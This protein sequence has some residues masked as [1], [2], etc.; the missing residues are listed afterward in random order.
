MQVPAGDR[1]DGALQFGEREFGRHQLEHHRAVF[2]LGAQ[3]RDRGGE[4]AAVV[5]AHRL[6]ERGQLA[7]VQR[8]L[9]AVAPRF[10]DQPRLV[11]QLV[12][13]EHLLLVPGRAADAE[14]EPQPLAPAERAAE[15]AACGGS[16]HCRAAA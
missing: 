15:L 6:A 3:P 12:A 10:L 2:Q 14:A 7:R 16:A 8:R 9:A 5:E 11:E 1:L 4:D 13:V